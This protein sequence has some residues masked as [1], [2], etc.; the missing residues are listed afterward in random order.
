MNWII[1]TLH[2]TGDII[3]HMNFALVVYF[4]GSRTV[5]NIYDVHNS[6]IIFIITRKSH[7]Y[8]VRR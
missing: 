5:G 1:N 6:L 3:T 2:G 4:A 8:L 7:L